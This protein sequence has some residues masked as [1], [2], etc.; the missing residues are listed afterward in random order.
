[1]SAKFLGV[2]FSVWG[3]LAL[4]VALLF[5]FVW[6]KERVGDAHGLR[7]VI[8]RWAHTLVWLLLALSFFMRATN[9]P[10]LANPIALLAGLT[11]AFFIFTLIS[12]SE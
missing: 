3:L 8:L 9:L 6:P 1:V 4:G 11:Y 5:A 12:R 10:N 7:L 2:P